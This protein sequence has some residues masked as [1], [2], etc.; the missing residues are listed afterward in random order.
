MIRRVFF[1]FDL[2]RL[3]TLKVRFLKQTR[4]PGFLFHIR[5]SCLK[6]ILLGS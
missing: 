3:D 6:G 1:F 5:A 2:T 4:F